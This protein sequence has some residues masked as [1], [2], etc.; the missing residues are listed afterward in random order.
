MELFST[1]VRLKAFLP[2]ASAEI[3]LRNMLSIKN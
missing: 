3:A 1:V 2:F